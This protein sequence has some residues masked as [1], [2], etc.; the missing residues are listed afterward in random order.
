MNYK[1]SGILSLAG[2]FI[3]I[4]CSYRQG[5]VAQTQQYSTAS[6]IPAL[7]SF[8]LGYQIATYHSQV[9]GESR[10]YGVCLPPGYEQNRNQRYPVI[11]LLHGGH[12]SPTSWFQKEKGDA[13]T[14]LQQLY[15]AG[16][17]PPS[18]VITP[19]G[20]DHRGSSPYWD[21]QYI[22]GPN[23][24]VSTAI[25]EEL[26]QVIQ[27]RYRTL[28]KPSFWAIG[29]LSSGAW[30]A[31]NIGL[32]HFN[33]F[34]ILFSHSGYFVDKTGP[35]NSPINYVKTLPP[36][37]KKQLRVY[38]D[39][40]TEDEDSLEQT[41][42]FHQVLSRLQIFNIMNQFPGGH[43]W[44]YWR[45]HLRDSLTFVGEQFQQRS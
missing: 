18:I 8:P 5:A 12:G 35:Q 3:L 4:S 32:H 2:V 39:T 13:L 14:T 40:G 11:F 17:L 22:D 36:Q 34:S 44:H 29:G 42:K 45:H 38:L 21:P 19:D 6:A 15:G 37:A 16:K 28:L 30:G 33:H 27:N 31:V 10:T 9:M 43:T 26:V 24:N 1:Q 20:N 25:G 7:N 23:G 41:H